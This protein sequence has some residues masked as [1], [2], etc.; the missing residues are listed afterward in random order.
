MKIEKFSKV[1]MLLAGGAGTATSFNIILFLA[2]VTKDEVL[3]WEPGQITKSYGRGE[4]ISDFPSTSHVAKA[5]TAIFSQSPSVVEFKVGRRDPDQTVPDALDVIENADSDWFALV[6]LRGLSDILAG[7]SWIEAQDIK[8]MFVANYDQDIVTTS[9]QSIAAILDNLGYRQTAL[10]YNNQTGVTLPDADTSLTVLD[11]VCSVIVSNS[12]Q[13]EKV[14]VDAIVEDFEY[15]IDIDAEQVS[16]TTAENYN[17]QINKI[18]ILRAIDSFTYRL[19]IAGVLINYVATVPTDDEEVIKDALKV[20]I[21][22]DAVLQQKMGAIDDPDDVNSLRLVGKDQNTA[23]EVLPGENILNTPITVLVPPTQKELAAILQG[24]LL[25]NEIINDLVTVIL[26]GENLIITEKVAGTGFTIDTS[27]NL[28][29]SPIIF[30]YGFKVGDPLNVSGSEVLALNG[31][32]FISEVP[33]VNQFKFPTNAVNGVPTGVIT[34]EVNYTFPDAGMAGMGLAHPNGSLDYA[35]QDIIA[36]RPET[37]QHLTN[38]VINNL[39]AHNVNVFHVSG[40]K[41]LLW[42][43]RTV[44]GLFIDTVIDGLMYLP[45]R[46]EEAIF[47]FITSRNKVPMSDASMGSLKIAMDDVL[48]REGKDR[49]ITAPFIENKVLF[50]ETGFPPGARAGDHYVS[51]VPRIQDVPINDRVNFRRIPS[52]VEF[53]FQSSGGIH[54]IIITGTLHQ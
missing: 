42:E 25:A 17:T 5:A 43:G 20:A 29:D 12:P 22:A 27:D 10:F 1:N 36:V 2:D 38:D 47:N 30:N 14:S 24:L 41:R 35:H 7:A 4:I 32:E 33:A 39:E 52:G 8:F 51:R 37:E 18:T 19:S 48:E 31:D 49:G 44:G 15:T 16:H 34:I 3:N 6:G 50:P 21:N 45:T 9:D 40:T 26:E 11:E 54:I 13:T 46:V 23:Y 28:T 53:E